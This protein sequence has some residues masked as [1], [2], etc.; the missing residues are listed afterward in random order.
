MSFVHGPPHGRTFWSSAFDDVVKDKPDGAAWKWKVMR[1]PRGDVF[2]SVAVTASKSLGLAGPLL[3]LL[4]CPSARRGLFLFSPPFIPA[5]RYHVTNAD[6]HSR[7]L[8]RTL[9]L[10]TPARCVTPLLRLSCLPPFPLSLRLSNTELVRRPINPRVCESFA[11]MHL[12]LGNLTRVPVSGT[13]ATRLPARAQARPGVEAIDVMAGG[14]KTLG[15]S[16]LGAHSLEWLYGEWGVVRAWCVLF[17]LVWSVFYMGMGAAWHCAG[18]GDAGRREDEEDAESARAPR[19][20]LVPPPA[21]RFAVRCAWIGEARRGHLA[22]SPPARETRWAPPFAGVK[23]GARPIPL[24]DTLLSGCTLRACP[25]FH[26]SS[27]SSKYSDFLFFRLSRIPNAESVK[28]PISALQI[29]PFPWTVGVSYHDRRGRC[30]GGGVGGG[31][32]RVQ[33]IRS[34]GEEWGGCTMWISRHAMRVD[35][36]RRVW[37]YRYAL[38]P[39]FAA[40]SWAQVNA[41]VSIYHALRED[42][43]IWMATGRGVRDIALS[44]RAVR[45][46]LRSSEGI[47]TL[48]IRPRAMWTVVDVAQAYSGPWGVSGR[49][50]AA[51]PDVRAGS[52]RGAGSGNAECSFDVSIETFRAPGTRTASAALHP[53]SANAVDCLDMGLV[54]SRVGTQAYERKIGSCAGCGIRRQATYGCAQRASWMHAALWRE[55]YSGSTS[56]SVL[57]SWRFDGMSAARRQIAGAHLRLC[58]D[59]DVRAGTATRSR[60]TEGL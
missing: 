52:G 8:K 9:S 40:F 22:R 47:W 11:A 46:C 39:P 3:P 60:L 23:S 1:S 5:L 56:L 18:E 45:V 14:L 13:Y 12:N 42:T 10:G 34:A 37:G 27:S 21:L 26:L 16:F 48:S 57:R 49:A 28:R 4:P 36:L 15:T 24:K 20:F 54:L 7:P 19:S 29:R 53:A 38:A 59:N 33:G 41:L 58:L 31:G 17:S 44:T 51:A 30:G 35:V 43:R 55:Q 2:V 50:R 6:L 25:F 32:C